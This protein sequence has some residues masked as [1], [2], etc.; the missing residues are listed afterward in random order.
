MSNAFEDANSF[1]KFSAAD[2]LQ[3]ADGDGRTNLA[4]SITGTDPRDPASCL[5]ANVTKI[6]GGFRIQFTAQTGKGYT[7][8]YRDSL[9]IGTW[10]RLTDIAAPPTTQTATFND[11]A[12]LAQ[13]FYRVVT[14]AT[15]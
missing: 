3:D 15:P 5:T 2:A 14:P 1:D 13:R 9:T 4:E 6:G 8:Q 10:Q 12:A 11:L 7:I